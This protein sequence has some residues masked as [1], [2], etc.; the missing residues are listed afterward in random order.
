MPDS[1]V[2][3]NVAQWVAMP[4]CRV[5][6]QGVWNLS[7]PPAGGGIQDYLEPSQ[8]Q[9]VWKMGIWK[10]YQAEPNYVMV[11]SADCL[12]CAHPF[13]PFTSEQLSTLPHFRTK[14]KSLIQSYSLQQLLVVIFLKTTL[15]SSQLEHCD[16]I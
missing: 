1:P 16:M 14:A 7:F 4:G 8:Q 6:S 5:H 12:K 15:L 10:C 13:H 11:I 9:V 2:R 3:T